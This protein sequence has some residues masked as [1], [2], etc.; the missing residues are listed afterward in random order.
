M[1]IAVDGDR[2]F[3]RSPGKGGKVKRVRSNPVVEVAP[4]TA[5]GRPTGPAVAM[6]ARLLQ[7]EEFRRAGRLLAHKYPM[8]QGAFVPLVHRLFRAKTGPTVHIE[9]TPA[10]APS[11]GRQA[12]PGLLVVRQARGEGL[13]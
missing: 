3:V 12:E 9:L 11:A 13:P 4:C 1:S 10:A 8:L 7:G 5:L 6:R 2:A